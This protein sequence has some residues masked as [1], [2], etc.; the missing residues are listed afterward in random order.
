[1]SR[2]GRCWR[3]TATSP[4]ATCP[5]RCW[6]TDSVELLIDLFGYLS[7]IVHGLTI[8]AQSMALGGVGFLV[9]LARP[10][11]RLIGGGGAKS[12]AVMAAWFAVALVLAETATVAIESA[13][14]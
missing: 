11:W 12:V 9:L 4:A 7:I 6:S 5:S 1:M 14:L 3:L 2:A 8:L 13:V 10:L